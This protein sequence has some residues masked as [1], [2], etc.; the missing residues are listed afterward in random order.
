M[1]RL[2]RTFTDEQRQA[3]AQRMRDIQ[4]RRWEKKAETKIS[5]V[6]EGEDVSQSDVVVVTEFVVV[7]PPAVR[8]SQGNTL[9]E[10]S[11]QEGRVGAGV[12]G[13]RMPGDP[14]YR[15]QPAEVQAVI[16]MMS[17]ERKAKLEQIQ[18]R[19]LQTPEGQE[20]LARLES[21]K[22]L[23]SREVHLIVRTDGTM[24][25]QYGPCVCGLPKREWHKICLKEK[26]NAG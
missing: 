6:Q 16:A 14:K 17:P 13:D 19:Q 4:K 9:A 5:E 7:D 26:P 25:S 18:S 10:L 1:K 15:V 3:M 20:A 12:F 2:K 23:G 11:E 8:S 22:R 21:Q 24:V